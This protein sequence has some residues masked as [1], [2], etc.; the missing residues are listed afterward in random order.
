MKIYDVIIAGGG[1]AGLNAAL[2]LARCRRSVILFDDGNPRNKYSQGIHNYLTRDGV[3]PVDFLRIA[4]DEIR[5]YGV[6]MIKSS[7]AD[8]VKK[9][10]NFIVT[11][12]KGN[13]YRSK[14][15][16]LATGLQDILPPIAGIESFYGKSIFH[17]PYCDGWEVRDKR[18]GIYSRKRAG[19]EL[20]ISL[21]S[22][23]RSVTLYT[24]G[25]NYLKPA[26]IEVLKIKQI[27]FF[28]TRI[29][30]IEGYNGRM[31]K[32]VFANDSSDHCDALFFATGYKQQANLPEKLGCKMNRNG[33]VVTNRLGETGVYGL[34]VAGDSSID[35]QFIIVAAAEG[36]KAAVSINKQLQKEELV[37][38]K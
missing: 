11:D 33:L 12:K 20:A 36:A 15:L 35:V 5:M 10:N 4:K 37:K 21:K 24:D 3:L 34:Y 6:R 8:A 7:V 38:R 29:E 9:Q 18:I 14:K 32:I 16:L 19:V 30:S 25:I 27:K 17:C 13:S 26:D 1:P 28:K 22:W 31:K 2:V 23:S